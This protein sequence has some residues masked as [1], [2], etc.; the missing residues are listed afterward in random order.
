MDDKSPDKTGAIADRLAKEIKEVRVVH[1][2][3]NKGIGQAMISG[4]KHASK[5]WVFYTDG[6]AQYDVS[7]LPLFAE[8]TK[9]FDIL[10]GYR[11]KRAEGLKRVFISR[12]FHLL[13]LSLFGIR[14][15]DI[16]C[17][18]KL[19]HRRFLDKISFY[20]HS[21]L[22]DAE[23]LIQARLLKFPV[24]EIGVHHYPRRFG[25]SHCLKPRLILS[26]LVDTFKLRF[27]LWKIT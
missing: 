16:D 18:F 24:K 22:V 27:K 11:L 13:I 9:D 17:S 12:C 5:E 21:G 15:K 7:E 8:H 2:L 6:D 20:T 26:M 4:Y 25:S 3:E 23:I 1:H 19:I 10:V 14:F